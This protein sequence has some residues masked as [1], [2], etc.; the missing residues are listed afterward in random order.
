MEESRTKSKVD[1]KEET[2]VKDEQTSEPTVHTHES[3]LFT[4][5]LG[6]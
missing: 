6:N 2:P 1:V 3:L 4:L 5:S